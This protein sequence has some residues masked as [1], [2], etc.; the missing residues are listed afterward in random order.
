[1]RDSE[2]ANVTKMLFEIFVW[3]IRQRC[4][5]DGVVEPVLANVVLGHQ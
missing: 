1:M 5:S 3:K 2:P 4:P